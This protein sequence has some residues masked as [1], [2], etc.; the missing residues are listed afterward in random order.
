MKEQDTTSGSKNPHE[1]QISNLPDK[2]FQVMVIKMFAL[3]GDE[4][5]NT[6]RTST[7]RWTI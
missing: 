3:W 4:W 7:K 2:G 5:M 6:V 1:M